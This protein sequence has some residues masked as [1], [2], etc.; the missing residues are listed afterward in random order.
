MAI[1]GFNDKIGDGLKLLVE[2]MIEALEVKAAAASPEK[3]LQRELLE[4][5]TIICVL[6]TAKGQVL[7]E[8]FVGLNLL[9]KAMFVEVERELRNS[10]TND[11]RAVCLR[12]GTEFIDLLAR[13]EDRSKALRQ[14]NE[15]T[16][17]TTEAKRLA[18]WALEASSRFNA[19]GNLS[20]DVQGR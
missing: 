15:S 4:L 3:A 16:L 12:I 6:R 17:I 20:S 8:M 14:Q 5:D 7:P 9:A 13:T 19:Q 11:L 10:V 2:G 18:Q 1:C